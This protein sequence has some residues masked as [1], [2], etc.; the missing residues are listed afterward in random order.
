MPVSHLNTI[1]ARSKSYL[2]TLRPL[3]R[4]LAVSALLHLQE[5]GYGRLKVLETLRSEARQAQIYGQGRSVAD[6]RKAGLSVRYAAPGKRRVTNAT[7]SKSLH[8]MGLALDIS[9]D[10]YPRMHWPK[11]ASVFAKYGF[12]W[13]GTWTSADCYHFEYRGA[14]TLKQIYAGQRP[15]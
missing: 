6:M 8:C 7:P 9:I 11:I 5:A 1:D 3:V 14:L 10:S 13:G 12:E 4:D 2:D 15:C